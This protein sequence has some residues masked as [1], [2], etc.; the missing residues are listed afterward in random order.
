MMFLFTEMVKTVVEQVWKERWGVSEFEMPNSSLEIDEL[1][2]EMSVDW[3]KSESLS[4]GAHQ[5]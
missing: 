1:T 5:H 2:K 3:E 4:L